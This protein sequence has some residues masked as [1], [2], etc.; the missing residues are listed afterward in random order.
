M[1]QRFLKKGDTST[2]VPN[3]IESLSEITE[4]EAT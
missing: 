2:F 4:N 3:F 1:S